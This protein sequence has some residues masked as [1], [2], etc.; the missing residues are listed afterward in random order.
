MGPPQG[1]AEGVENLPRPAAHT[2]PHAS[3]KDLKDHQVQPMDRR[4]WWVAEWAAGVGP[5]GGS[6]DGAGC[7]RAGGQPVPLSQQ[8]R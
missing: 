2:P 4:W 7:T 6:P 3:Q 1:R 5:R 8:T